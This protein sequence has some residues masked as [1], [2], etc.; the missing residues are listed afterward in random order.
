MSIAETGSCRRD[1]EALDTF[2]RQLIVR[3]PRVREG[4][5]QGGQ[6]LAFKHT[7]YELAER[8]VHVVS[9]RAL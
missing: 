9:E 3:P 6:R 2:L 7:L 4:G 1:D 8:G 5:C